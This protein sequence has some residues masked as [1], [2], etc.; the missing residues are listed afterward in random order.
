MNSEASVLAPGFLIASPPLGDPNFDKTVVLLAVHS[1]GGALGF[2]V[3]RPAPMTL[4]E[5]L[6]FAGYGSDLKDPAPVYLGGPVQPS[7][8]WILCLDPALGAEESG[9][10]PVGSRVRV[11]S[12]R[13]AFDAL[14][15]DAVRGA[16]AADPRRRTVLLGY[17][18]WGPGQLEREIAA[19]A[20]LPVPLDERILFD[21]AADRRWEQAYAVLG[22][23]PI[24]VMSMRTIG[25]A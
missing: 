10:I 14:A 24:E 7:S 3:N 9:V 8:G 6:S 21:V 22:L 5:L 12:S 15:A 19:G 2:V 18:G 16:V 4:G 23:S 25:E 17:S 13:G 20:W 1:E 11:T